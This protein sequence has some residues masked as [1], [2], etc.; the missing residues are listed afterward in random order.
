[1]AQ[2]ITG[3]SSTFVN[4]GVLLLV[5]CQAVVVVVVVVIAGM[6]P[7]PLHYVLL[8]KKPGWVRSAVLL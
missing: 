1:M 3:V 2:S 4:T 7:A 6:D 5:L 8:Q